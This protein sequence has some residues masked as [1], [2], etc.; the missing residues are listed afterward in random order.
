MDKNAMLL[1]GFNYLQVTVECIK[2]GNC[3]KILL[4]HGADL[5]SVDHAVRV[6]DNAKSLCTDKNYVLHIQ[7][8]L[9]FN[10]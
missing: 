5:A 7:D 10:S 6:V 4:D 9:D 8:P 1:Q 3:V 2:N